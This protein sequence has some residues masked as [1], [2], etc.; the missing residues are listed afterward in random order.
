[1]QAPWPYL[2]LQSDFAQE[3][4]RRPNTERNSPRAHMG[5]VA[6]PDTV[7]NQASTTII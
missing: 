4:R 7:M 2:N 1:M 3:C 5:I 6:S